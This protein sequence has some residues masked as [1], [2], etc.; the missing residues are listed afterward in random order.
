MC[1]SCHE[2][3]GSHGSDSD[4]NKEQLVFAVHLYATQGSWD[5][6]H[7]NVPDRP[8]AKVA[9]VGCQLATMALEIRTVTVPKGGLHGRSCHPVRDVS[10][11]GLS[12]TR[13]V[14]FRP[15]WQ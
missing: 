3:L 2:C 5:G 15:P 1:E 4:A 12:C 7:D 11:F 14:D 8:S 6:L 9:H 10:A 13:L